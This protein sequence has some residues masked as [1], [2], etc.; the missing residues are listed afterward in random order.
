MTVD[1]P[2]D[3]SDAKVTHNAPLC[4]QNMASRAVRPSPFAHYYDTDDYVETEQ[5]KDRLS[6]SRL[7][8][9]GRG[10]QRRSLRER[11]LYA[12]KTRLL[13]GYPHSFP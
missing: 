3:R 13:T 9:R 10:R 6:C 8:V 7:L 1:D 5:L 12:A 2:N 4:H 11:R